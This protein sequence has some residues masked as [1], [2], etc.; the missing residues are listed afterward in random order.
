MQALVSGVLL[1]LI[2]GLMCAGLSFIFGITRI[3]N[4]AQGE[5][6]MLGM[7]AAAYA[8]GWLVSNHFS[9]TVPSIIFVVVVTALIL[10]VVGSLVYFSVI[11]PVSGMRVMS[12]EGGGGYS[13]LVLTLG[14][15]LI[16]ANGALL[17]FGAT[18]L[19]IDNPFA[20]TAIQVPLW[21]FESALVF[22]NRAQLL[23][24]ALA[25]VSIAL[26]MIILKY[27]LLGKVLRAAADDPEAATFMGISIDNSFGIAFGLSAALTGVAGV[28]VGLYYT[29]QPFVGLE[30]VILMYA[31]VVLGGIGT[32][33][34]AFIGGLIIGVVEQMAAVVLPMQLQSTTVFVVFLLVLLWKPAGLFGKRVNRL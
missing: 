12:V 34:G 25:V 32:V 31:G 30:F 19:T 29:F 18:P 23:G 1:G 27:T 26:V 10:Y 14:V 7:Y 24:A 21:P 8:V 28:L 33:G 15:S 20:A 5:F 4:F 13:Q 9:I 22:L 17:V 11:R 3:I 16:L 6:L 2:Y